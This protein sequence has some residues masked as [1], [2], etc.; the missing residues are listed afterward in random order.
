[1]D[2]FMRIGVDF[3]NTIVCYDESF[4]AMAREE[5]LVPANGN[6][7]SKTDI[8][9]AVRALPEGEYQWQRLQGL[10]YGRYID[11]ARLFDGVAGFFAQVAQNPGTQIVIISHKTTL[12]H[13]D[14][15]KTNLHDAA[16]TFL[17]NNGLATAQTFF[18]P[19]RE[20]KLSR[21]AQQNC[22]VFID[23]LPEVLLDPAFPKTC[24]KILFS[25]TP[26]NGLESFGSW[27]E[28]HERLFR[29]RS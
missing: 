13:H 7:T 27:Q 22:D 19:T 21:I 5:K 12:A 11:R 2:S 15:M 1:M 28:I 6:F 25:Q 8:R 16:R 4:V 26:E 20:E 3:D 18:E 17:Q 29:P 14:P 23:D 10:V 9:S 24:E